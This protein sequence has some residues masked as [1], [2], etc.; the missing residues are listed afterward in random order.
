M[1]DL[2]EFEENFN[3]KKNNNFEKFSDIKYIY[4]TLQEN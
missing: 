4:Y 3:K 2:Q 1:L